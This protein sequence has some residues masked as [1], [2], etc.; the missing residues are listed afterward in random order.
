MNDLIPLLPS[1]LLLV[2]AGLGYLA[3]GYLAE[4]GKNAATK[5]DVAVITAQIEQVR[6]QVQETSSLKIKRLETQSEQLLAFHD[7]AIEILHERFAANFGDFPPDNGK[8]LLAYQSAF[9]HNIVQLLRCF[10]RL[11]LFLPEDS[12]LLAKANGMV[13]AA[14]KA[15]GAFK[16]NFGDVKGSLLWEIDRSQSSTKEAYREAVKET[17]AANR[18]F[19][20][21]IQPHIDEYQESLES[22]IVLLNK[23]MVDSGA[24]KS[25]A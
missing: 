15:Q 9:H 16:A 6:A 5:E 18:K 12:E 14:I 8:S 4:K 24:G 19:W 7:V 21:A 17:D 11:V 23:F 25:V 20:G 10:Q 2:G 1:V 22:F 13:K 3:R